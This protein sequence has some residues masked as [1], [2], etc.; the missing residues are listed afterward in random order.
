MCVVLPPGTTWH[1]VIMCL[2]IGVDRRA[3]QELIYFWGFDQD[4]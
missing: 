4:T 3:T 1:N 2:P